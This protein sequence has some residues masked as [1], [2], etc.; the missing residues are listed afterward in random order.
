MARSKVRRKA[1]IKKNATKR[2]NVA[3]NKRIKEME[4]WYKELDQYE[5][6]A[7]ANLIDR[8]EIE[9]ADDRPAAD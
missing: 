3:R 8:A 7:I 1:K 2:E 5:N 4:G 9:E 6:Q